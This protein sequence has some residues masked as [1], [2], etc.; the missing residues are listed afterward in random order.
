MTPLVW[1]L[2]CAAT[3]PTASVTT[4]VAVPSFPQRAP[5]GLV[6]TCRPVADGQADMDVAVGAEIGAASPV[7]MIGD[8]PPASSGYRT[9]LLSS[10]RGGGAVTVAIGRSGDGSG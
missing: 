6:A 9:G 7:A 10:P 4:S 1:I 5:A 8:D 3:N 2:R